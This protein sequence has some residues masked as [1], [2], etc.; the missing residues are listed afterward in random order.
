ME[1]ALR[2]PPKA[3]QLSRATLHREFLT[4]IKTDRELLK[5]TLRAAWLCDDTLDHVPSQD[6]ESLVRDRYSQESW[7]LKS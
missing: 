2:L 1:R 6:I 7:N 4:S 5:K 3:T